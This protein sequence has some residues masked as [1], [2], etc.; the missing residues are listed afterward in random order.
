M[1]A[2]SNSSFFISNLFNDLQ[3]RRIVVVVVV[4]VIVV[5]VVVVIIVVVVVIVVVVDIVIVIAFVSS[6]KK[7]FSFVKL[8]LKNESQFR[9]IV[10]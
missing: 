10:E 6:C 2:K 7:T 5:V 1:K 3:F 8:L 4:V 9:L